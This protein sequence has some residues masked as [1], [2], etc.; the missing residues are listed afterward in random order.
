MTRVG[1]SFLFRS[2]RH[3]ST[4]C[5]AYLFF[6]FGY[7]ARDGGPAIRSSLDCEMSETRSISVDL[8]SQLAINLVGHLF[9]RCNMVTE[10]DVSSRAER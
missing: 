6:F 9:V 4:R 7:A 2:V 1:I 10:L 5:R 3:L 8:V